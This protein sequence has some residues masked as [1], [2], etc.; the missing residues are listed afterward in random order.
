MAHH[1]LVEEVVE[2]EG[3]HSQEAPTREHHKKAHHHRSIEEGHQDNF[4]KI[5]ENTRVDVRTWR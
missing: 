3:L 1:N 5:S 2:E 4:S